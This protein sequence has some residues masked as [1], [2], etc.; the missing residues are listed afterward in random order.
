MGS[1]EP[2]KSAD[3][4]LWRPEFFGVKPEKLVIKGGYPA[5]GALGEG[6]ASISQAEPQI[7]G[8]HWGGAGCAAAS[9]SI[10]F[11]S[12]AAAA[13]GFRRRIGTRRRA[14][15]VVGTRRVGKRH[16]LYNQANPRIEIDPGSAE[17]RIDGSALADAARR[18]PP[19][20]PPATS[21]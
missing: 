5:W 6:N 15:P 9:L 20:E 13:G 3:I 14:I 1:L 10:D 19:D 18:G 8:P 17:I 4:V 7:Y 21:W 12:A 2:G 11:V 16:M